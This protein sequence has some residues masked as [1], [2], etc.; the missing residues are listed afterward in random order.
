MYNFKRHGILFLKEKKNTWYKK[1][2]NTF[3]LFFKGNLDILISNLS[4]I[5][6]RLRLPI[7]PL[8]FEHLSNERWTFGSNLQY[9]HIWAG[10]NFW[11]YFAHSWVIIVLIIGSD[12]IYDPNSFHHGSWSF[13]FEHRTIQIKHG[14]MYIES[15][16]SHERCVYK[17]QAVS[18][19]SFVARAW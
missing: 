16:A 14:W 19:S 18:L 17:A 3:A 7:T 2:N 12:L 8:A 10:H 11:C 4:I 5:G 9:L 13:K 1:V 6:V 15:I